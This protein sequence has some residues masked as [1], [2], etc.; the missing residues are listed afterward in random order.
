MASPT[1]QKLECSICLELFRVP[2]T[3]PCGHSFCKRC[4]SDHWQVPAGAERG[5]TCPECRR[6]FEQPPELE[7]NV[8][9]CN[10][11]E[12]VR[13]GEARAAGTEWRE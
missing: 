9:L 13:D 7:K 11:V 10:V 5:Y 1:S 12:L 8:T 4:I 6:A 2:V 3:L